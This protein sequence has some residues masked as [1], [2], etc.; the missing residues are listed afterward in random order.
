MV[1]AQD[2]NLFLECMLPK[3]L[4]NK[5]DHIEIVVQSVAIKCVTL[6]KTG[7]DVMT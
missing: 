4:A 1:G 3:I 2:I 5:F 7:A 6:D